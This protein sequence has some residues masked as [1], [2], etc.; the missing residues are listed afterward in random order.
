LNSANP[1][2]LELQVDWE[3]QTDTVFQPFPVP[4]LPRLLLF[5]IDEINLRSLTLELV[6]DNRLLVMSPEQEA[7]ETP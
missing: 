7:D 4:T 6:P 2:V 1:S 5:Q 3:L